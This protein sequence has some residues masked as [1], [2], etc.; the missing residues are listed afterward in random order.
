[1][2]DPV[3]IIASHSREAVDQNCACPSVG[4]SPMHPSPPFSLSRQVHR[5]PNLYR[6]PLDEHSVVALDLMGNGMVAVLDSS[7][8]RVLD[9][10]SV[11]QAPCAVSE[12]LAGLDPAVIV[13]A[14]AA[15]ARLGFLQPEYG[16]ASSPG[17]DH[18]I[19]TAWLHVASDCPLRCSYCYVVKKDARM[20]EPVARAAVDA[21][22][23]SAISHGFD[24]V[25]LKYAG[26]E[27]LLNWPMVRQTHAY[28]QESAHQFG[29]YTHEVLL[30]SGVGLDRP[31]I[32]FLRSEAIETVISIDGLGEVH[33]RQRG[34]G[35]FALA[36]QAIDRALAAG[37]RL[38]LSITVTANN[39]S[40][41]ASV[42]GFAIERDLRFNLN[43]IR[44]VACSPGS[45]YNQP[46]ADRLIA[47]LQTALGVIETRLPN[48]R[49]I[50]GLLDR[51]SF[52]TERSSACGAGSSYL[53]VDSDGQVSAC[54]MDMEHPVSDVAAADPLAA[55]A[56]FAH[57]LSDILPQCRACQWRGWC[58]GGCPLHRSRAGDSPDAS[59]YC[60][61][62]RA[63]FPALLKLEGLRLKRFG[64]PMAA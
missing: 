60:R 29:L 17:S 42:V 50:D 41:L 27:P 12:H 64:V 13:H 25:K 38:G 23:R 59:P 18:R 56:T 14:S 39:V 31:A 40:D 20:G 24:E 53:V 63:I 49:I 6:A 34:Q 4:S 1:V 55:T 46:D 21:I 61:V 32:D 58:G 9:A 19:L 3:C 44:P 5:A 28:L 7:A 57:T 47:G 2:P 54:Q 35:S 51:S 62:Y 45:L 48:R 10:Y 30:T 33:D 16:V 36:A 15:L 52:G 26:G 11:P 43:F 22:L 8:C 37:V